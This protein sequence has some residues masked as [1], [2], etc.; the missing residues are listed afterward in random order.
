MPRPK[1]RCGGGRV[2]PKGTRP[3]DRLRAAAG[4]E[5]QLEQVLLTDAADAA[6]LTDLD[7]AEYWASSI[8]ALF[9]PFV[10]ACDPAMAAPRVLAA[11]EVCDDRAAA[12]AVAAAMGVYGPPGCRAQAHDLLEQLAGD[13]E[14]PPGWAAALGDVV[15][16]R[17]VLLTDPWGDE[18]AVWI[19]FQRPDGAVR[20]MGVA[21][22]A[23]AGKGASSLAYGPAVETV[24]AEFKQWP[25]AVVEE[26]SLGDARVIV[27][28][29]LEVQDV[30]AALRHGGDNGGDN[31]GDDEMMDEKLRALLEH[32]IGLLPACGEEHGPR[33]LTD[34]EIDDLRGEFRAV[35]DERDASDAD[36]V[37]AAACRFSEAWW[38]G[39][40]LCWSPR[41]GCGVRECVDTGQVGVRR[42][43]AR[44]RRV[45]V[46][47]M[48]ALRGAATGPRA[49]PVAGEPRGGPRG[50]RRYEGQRGGPGQEV[51]H[52]QHRHRH[53]RRRRRLRQRR[54]RAGMDGELQRP[55]PQRTLPA[56][57][58]PPIDR[59]A[60]APRA[61]RVGQLQHDAVDGGPLTSFGRCLE[62][63]T[64]WEH[65]DAVDGG[66]LTSFGRCLELGTVWEHHDAV[67]GGPLTSFGRCL[68]LGTV[69]EHHD[70]VDGGP[71]TSLG[72]YCS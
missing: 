57:C 53:D 59:P 17:S 24:A 29:A 70:A 49:G 14:P 23:T 72:R 38:D 44:R 45:G 68:E 25:D 19:D 7:V 27:E 28:A 1:R 9:R 40:V 60:G 64:V 41:R 10:Y 56:G 39:D 37:L 20:G 55:S 54:R 5:P 26:I 46:P 16:R 12:G 43:V 22:H 32:R 21:V 15:P 42:G 66:P 31:G 63:G 36:T 61:E 71:L 2:T 58:R 62:L 48:A 69:W 4:P 47:A 51:G 33:W 30:A 35:V 52:H 11:A 18:R 3:G 50:V 6:V 65:H 67:D 13:G 8:Q 34:E